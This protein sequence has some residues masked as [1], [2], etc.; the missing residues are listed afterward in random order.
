MPLPTG[1]IRVRSPDIEDDELGRIAKALNQMA[2]SLEGTFVDL[3]DKN[4]M[5]GGAVGLRDAIRGEKN[6]HKLSARLL[7]I[8]T[9]YMNAPMG[10]VYLA[11]TDRNFKL[12]GSHAAQN[13]PATVKVG[14]GLIGQVIEHKKT[15]VV[16][17]I[18]ADY[19]RLTSSLG[20]TL[21]TALVI[22]PLVYENTCLGVIELGL[23]R[24]PNAQELA[25]IEANRE[26]VA[27]GVNTALDFVRLQNFL[28]ETQS[29]SEELQAQHEELENLNAE[30]EMQTQKLQ[31]SEEELRVQ[32]EE[33]QQTN[34]ELEE[35]SV[36][37]EEKNSDIQKKAAE[38][39]IATRYK[40]EFLANMSHELR[41]PLNSILLLSRLLAENT[42][43]NLNKDQVEYA[44]VIQSSG[45][46]LL[47][48]IDE[49]LDLSKIEAGQMQVDYERC[50]H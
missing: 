38:L 23:L 11:D 27:I 48:L 29:Q 20:H 1:I 7:S 42:D 2:A 21:P 26:A 18:P 30:L 36:L 35:R 9:N 32:Q 33:L 49:I 19:S 34:I 10:T 37:L 45:N 41:T 6:I 39:E 8:L 13:V 16:Q 15:T 3:K 47:G 44:Q 14:E 5:Q 25:F 28:E 40:S 12:T 4:W 22:I 31:A 17:D 46:G 24:K 43:K 50:G